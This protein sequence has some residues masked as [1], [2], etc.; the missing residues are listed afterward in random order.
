[1]LSAALQNRLTAGTVSVQL[2][3]WRKALHTGV[4][5]L[6]R[7][8]V[9]GP[10]LGAIQSPYDSCL[11]SVRISGTS[12]E[13]WTPAMG[14]RQG[15]PLSATLFGLFIDGLHSYLEALSP[16]AGVTGPTVAPASDDICL[17]AG[18]PG[19]CWTR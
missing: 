19:H 18:S 13:G 4:Q 15:C 16:D 2:H 8:G 9:Q 14:L 12:G 5:M 1:M 17:M 3:L 7:L 11:L 6:E 10:M